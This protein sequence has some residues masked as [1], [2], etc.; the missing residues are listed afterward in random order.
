M[1]RLQRVFLSLAAPLL[2]PLLTALSSSA[3]SRCVRVW[4]VYCLLPYGI[5]C[6]S[7]FA[8]PQDTIR[9][10]ALTREATALCEALSQDVVFQVEMC[11]HPDGVLGCAFNGT[12]TPDQLQV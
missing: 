12:V 4:W 1:A 8:I 3:Q 6:L 11:I 5:P 9:A 7:V 2:L 10:L